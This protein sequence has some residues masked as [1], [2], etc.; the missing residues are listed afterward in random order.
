VTEVVPPELAKLHAQARE[1]VEF[2][3][4]LP[5]VRLVLDAVAR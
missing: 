3:E 5:P 4:D 2:D 1:V